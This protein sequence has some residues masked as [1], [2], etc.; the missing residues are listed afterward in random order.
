MLMA[1]FFVTKNYT[2]TCLKPSFHRSET[3]I[4]ELTSA[5]IMYKQSTLAN[6]K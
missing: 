6:Y 5:T 3:E 4:E 1:L 2:K